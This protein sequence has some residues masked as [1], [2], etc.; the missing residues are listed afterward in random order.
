M[1]RVLI[2]WLQMKMITTLIEPLFTD[3]DCDDSSADIHLNEND[4]DCD[5]ISTDIDCIDSGERCFDEN[6]SVIDG[7]GADIDVMIPYEHYKHK[8]K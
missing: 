5:G 2:S 6:D 7:I 3:I 8:R 1:I 4:S